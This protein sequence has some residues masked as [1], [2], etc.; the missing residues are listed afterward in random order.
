MWPIDEKARSGRIS[1]WARP[2]S[3]P[4]IAFILAISIIK[5]LLLIFSIRRERGA[6]FCQV[7][8]INAPDQEVLDIT[9]G[10]QLWKGEAPSFIIIAVKNVMK[11]ET[12]EKIGPIIKIKEA[13]A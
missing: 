9:E 1:L 8:R 12:D 7:D 6:I 5:L 13:N 10:N 11:K 4:T 3:P 2:P